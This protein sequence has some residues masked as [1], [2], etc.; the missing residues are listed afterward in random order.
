MRFFLTFFYFFV[1]V[2]FSGLVV[3]GRCV[4]V[5]VSWSVCCFIGGCLVPVGWSFWAL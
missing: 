2:V 5:V 1:F 4:V 3:G